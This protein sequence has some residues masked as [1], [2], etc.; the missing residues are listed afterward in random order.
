MGVE[1]ED[2]V[3]FDV[4]LE[5]IVSSWV[6]IEG[7]VVGDSGFESDVGLL[8]TCYHCEVDIVFAVFIDSANWDG[9]E[10]AFY[11]F[12]FKANKAFRRRQ[13]IFIVSWNFLPVFHEKVQRVD[14]SNKVESDI[15]FLRI[16]EGEF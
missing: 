10:L 4:E 2:V 6:F 3:V 1:V 15:F 8:C 9:E 14:R 16:F 5:N 7:F 11:I 12:G 13:I